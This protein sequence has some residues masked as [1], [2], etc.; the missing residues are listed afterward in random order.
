MDNLGCTIKSIS[1]MAYL[2]RIMKGTSCMKSN[3]MSFI[4]AVKSV[5]DYTKEYK[6]WYIISLILM[7]LF[8]LSE[9]ITNTAF[10]YSLSNVIE[11]NFDIA[12]KYIIIYM[13]VSFIGLN[14]LHYYHHKISKKVSIKF[15]QKIRINLYEKIVKMSHSDFEKINVGELFATVEN[16]N[17]QMISILTKYLWAVTKVLYLIILFIIIFFIDFRVWILV[18]IVL[19]ALTIL[20]KIYIS[21]SKKI[22]NLEY[23]KTYEASTLLNQTILGFK[24]LKVLDA[25]KTYVKNIK[26][27]MM[28]FVV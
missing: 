23:E 1:F 19:L 8:I 21:K 11:K 27:L 14:V 12:I 4:K 24:E 3:N 16:A 28:S 18:A 6:K 17:E 20:T 9:I 7:V 15:A 26:I 25:E 10:S 22:T 13:I 5:I 2:Y